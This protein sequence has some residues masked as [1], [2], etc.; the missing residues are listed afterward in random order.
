MWGP[1]GQTRY[2]PLST[3]HPLLFYL[4]TDLWQKDAL[5]WVSQII[6]PF[7]HKLKMMS[8]LPPTV[9]TDKECT[10]PEQ[11]VD[12]LRPSTDKNSDV[13]ADDNYAICIEPNHFGQ[14]KFNWMNWV[15][16]YAMLSVAFVI[17]LVLVFE[18]VSQTLA[19]RFA[20]GVLFLSFVT[21]E[22]R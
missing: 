5:N 13:N 7:V 17:Y 3:R 6:L 1:G 4:I 9:P 22:V 20:G 2:N 16:L 15:D 8:L 10:V 19:F 18:I 12:A 21:N 14:A 11:P